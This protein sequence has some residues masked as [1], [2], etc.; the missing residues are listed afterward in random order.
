M[1]DLPQDVRRAFKRE[2]VA[3][4][5]HHVLHLTNLLPI[6]I[7]FF[8]FWP[9]FWFWVR[10]TNMGNLFSSSKSSLL[11]ENNQQESKGKASFRSKSV[12]SFSSLL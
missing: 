4:G 9:Q 5:L 8:F 3:Q 6:W 11:L 7:F 1:T 10:Q 2:L 12:L